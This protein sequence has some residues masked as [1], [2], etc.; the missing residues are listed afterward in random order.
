[1]HEAEFLKDLVVVFGCAAAVVYLF[2]SLKQS[3]IV[4]FVVTGVLVG[5]Y[6][7]SLIS[8]VESVRTLATVGLMILLFSLGLEF[9]LKKLMETRIAVLVTGPLQMLMTIALV[10]P[11][12]RYFGASLRASIIYGV[13]IGLSSTAVFMKMLAERGEV[14]SVH[15]RIGLGIAIFQD[16]CTIPFMIAIP[17]MAA[18]G[19]MWA[20][21]GSSLAKA[22]LLIAVVL[23]MAR[24]VFPF[25]LR[26][27]LKTRSKELFLIASTFLFLGTAWASAGVG[28]S[29][30]LGSFLAGL[31]L[32]ESEYGHHI[33][34]EVRPFRDSLNSLFFISIGMLVDPGFIAG[35]VKVILGMT[36]LIVLGKT[37]V[38]MIAVMA[39]RIPLQ[40]AFLTGAA[41]SQVGE[42]SFILLQAAAGLGIVGAGPYQIVLACSVVSMLIAPIV[43]GSSRRLVMKYARNWNP[44]ALPRRS[45]KEARRMPGDLRDHV[46]ICGF[47]LGGRN[48]ARVLKINKIPYVIIDLNE[49]RV[50]ESRKEGE[51]IIFGDCTNT[52]ILDI[53]GIRHCRVIVLVISDPL[54]TRLAIESARQ[55]SREIVVLTRTK[56]VSDMD[57]LWDQGSTEVIAEEFEASLEL[58]TRIL[59]VYNAPRS[60]V[61]AEI[62]SIRDQRFGIFRERHT[63]VPRIR[64][65]NDLD[66]FTETWQVPADYSWNGATIARTRLRTETGAIVLGIIRE[67]HTLNN[68]ESSEPIFSGDR[69]VLSGTK[70]QLKKAI[71]MLT[72]AGKVSEAGEEGISR[73]GGGN[74]EARGRESSPQMD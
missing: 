61:A 31:V 50:R 59:R 34:A 40:T 54:G 10:I 29:L 16:L 20:A 72:H 52:H 38:I 65:S 13:L 6:G 28:I 33:F 9:S 73:Q 19:A 68:P 55:M 71:L 23:V 37:F 47:G 41:L 67:N 64:L 21:I 48:I 25:V 2:H 46:I 18:E 57:V 42:F 11:A 8:D 4:G 70:D 7:L 53:A 35:S 30:A 12:A 44:K 22:V 60:L 17:L 43:F 58:M 27:I 66:V 62:K 63:T 74:P 56:Y 5:P 15:G 45:S 32:S 69:L 36:A 51:P 3:P 39:S 1:M 49:Q 14:D 24:Y 26:G